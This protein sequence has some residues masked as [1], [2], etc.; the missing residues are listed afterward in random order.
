VWVIE[1]YPDQIINRPGKATLPVVSGAVET[2]PARELLKLS[3]VERYGKNGNIGVTF[4][5]GFGMQN[6][7]IA[8]SV[9][10]DHHNIVIAGTNDADIAACAAA[11]EEMQGGLAVAANGKVLGCLPLPIGGLMSEQPS[12][13]VIKVL[14]EMTAV[15]HEL[16]GTLPAPFMTISF[17]SLPTVPELG[18]TDMG[19]VNVREHKLMSP[20]C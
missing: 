12:A 16:G 19:L 5:K 1:L 9:S 7:A 2:D 18:L 17:I 3:V 8:S 15:Y 10:H 11:V 14:E 20:F 13:E 6:G 4:V